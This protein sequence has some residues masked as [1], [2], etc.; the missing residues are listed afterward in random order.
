MT[1]AYLMDGP[2]LCLADRRQAMVER[3][4]ATL[5]ATEGLD[6]SCDDD[7]VRALRSGGY[8]AIDVAILAPEARMVAFQDVVAREMAGS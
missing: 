3:M 4:A 5:K 2:L 8:S 1:A 6:L 7:V